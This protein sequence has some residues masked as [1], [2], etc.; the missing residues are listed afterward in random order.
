MTSPTHIA[1]GALVASAVAL[2]SERW[3]KG[4]RLR[5]ALALAAA[6]LLAVVVHFLMDLAP[7]YNWVANNSL[8]AGYASGWYY[9]EGAALLPTAALLLILGGRRFWW[10]LL[11]IVVGLYPDI[12]KLAYLAL[13]IPA[14]F[15]IFE[16]HSQALSS[17]DFGLSK[18]LLT[19][20]DIA[21]LATCLAGVWRLN[22]RSTWRDDGLESGEQNSPRMNTD[23]HG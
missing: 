11:G 5:V 19:A 2:W 22:R 9:R 21:V 12:E 20:F 17:H 6:A 10:V 8:F 13:H 4:S 14:Q 18:P 3:R 1:A 15:V 23:G 7:H 16:W